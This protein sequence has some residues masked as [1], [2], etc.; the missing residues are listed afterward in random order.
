VADEAILNKRL[1]RE[2]VTEMRKK[3]KKHLAKTKTC[4]SYLLHSV[5]HLAVVEHVL[6]GHVELEDVDPV[7]AGG[8]LL[9]LL[10]RL[11]VQPGQRH[12]QGVVAAHLRKQKK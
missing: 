10:Q 6:A 9:Q 5:E 4:S 3:F 1:K 12:L 11:S 8:Q 2:K 7:L